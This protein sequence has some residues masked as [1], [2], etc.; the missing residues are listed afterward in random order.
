MLDKSLSIE[1]ALFDKLRVGFDMCLE[2]MLK[3]MIRHDSGEGVLTVKV[4]VSMVRDEDATDETG[5]PVFVPIFKHKVQTSI[6]L[7]SEMAGL[8]GGDVRMYYDPD[9]EE[10]R[11]ENPQMSL[12]E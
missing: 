8:S 12:Y 7:K 9:E 5:D 6:A 4:D 2:D 3:K 11:A 10:L 1:G